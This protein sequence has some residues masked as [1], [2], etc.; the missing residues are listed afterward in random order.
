VKRKTMETVFWD[1]E[2]LLLCEFLPPET[3]ISSD[4]CCGTLEKLHEA[5]K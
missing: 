3:T 4:K 2:G 5:I 1:C